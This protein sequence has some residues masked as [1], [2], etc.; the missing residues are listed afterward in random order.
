MESRVEA[1]L[2]FER[3]RLTAYQSETLYT[4]EQNENTTSQTNNTALSSL[5]CSGCVEIVDVAKIGVPELTP[6]TFT[7]ACSC[8]GF[9]LEPLLLLPLSRGCFLACRHTLF[10]GNRQSSE[11]APGHAL[12]RIVG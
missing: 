5:C 11:H 3:R 10:L 2:H 8:L 9:E 7:P 1:Y 12:W 4:D 6:Q